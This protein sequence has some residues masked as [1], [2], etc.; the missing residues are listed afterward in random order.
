MH[1]HALADTRPMVSETDPSPFTWKLY[2]AVAHRGIAAFSQHTPPSPPPQQRINTTGIS[3][4]GNS[5][6]AV[7]VDY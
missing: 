4:A 1:S 2:I 3:H 7:P 5:T 6:M